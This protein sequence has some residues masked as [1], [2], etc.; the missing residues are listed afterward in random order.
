MSA[1]TIRFESD[2]NEIEKIIDKMMVTQQALSQENQFL[3]RRVVEISKSRAQAVE[4][5]RIAN[6][7]IK[8]IIKQLKEG[9]K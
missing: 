8:K 6:Q 1:V 3:K 9:T 7:Q 5:N 4:K 2:L